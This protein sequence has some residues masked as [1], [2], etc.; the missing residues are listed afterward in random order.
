MTIDTTRTVSEIVAEDYRTAAVFQSHGID[1]CCGGKISLDEVCKKHDIN[2]GTL[3]ENLNMALNTADSSATD[4][5]SWPLD[6]LA[7]YIV[8]KHHRYVEE[9][10]PILRIYL[11]TI[12]GVH[13]E[14]HPELDE[15]NELFEASAGELTQHMKKE[16]LILFPIVRKMVKAKMENAKLEELPFG[17]VQN[18]IREMMKEHD[19]EGQRFRVIAAMSDN[20]AVPEDACNT[21]MVTLNYLKEFEADLHKHIHLENN[22]LFPKA[23]ELEKELRG[24][25]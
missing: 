22:I 11:N 10:I 15:I 1:F 21:Y 24:G 9:R 8:K 25:Q 5:N 20:Y 17:T 7:D 16:E 12:C 18:P 14:N 3:V 2:P 4:Y 6:L 19:N 23:I 13:G